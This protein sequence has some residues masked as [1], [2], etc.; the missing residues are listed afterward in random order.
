MSIPAHTDH[1]LSI[2]GIKHQEHKQLKEK[3]VHFCLQLVI[4]HRKKLEQELKTGTEAGD[5]EECGFLTLPASCG[6]LTL[7]S[8]TTQDRQSRG[9]HHPQG[10]GHFSIHH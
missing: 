7:L 10:A 5:T 1:R 3:R 2:A 8:Y 4:H 6:L 9:E